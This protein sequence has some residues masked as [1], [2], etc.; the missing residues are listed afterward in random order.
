MGILEAL[1]V[2]ALVALWLIPDPIG[3]AIKIWRF[4]REDRVDW[5]PATPNLISTWR[6]GHLTMNHPAANG[7]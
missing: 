4:L 2:L 5:W 6:A 3:L 7:L 1:G